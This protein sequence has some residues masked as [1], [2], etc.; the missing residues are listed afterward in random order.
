MEI[1][2]AITL[3]LASVGMVVGLLRIR[4]A[5]SRGATLIAVGGVPVAICFWWTGVAP[6]L[7]GSVAIA[8]LIRSRRASKT[9]RP[10]L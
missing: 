3:I 7:A 1:G 6:V 9:I 8:G 5:K 2:V 10:L 4:R